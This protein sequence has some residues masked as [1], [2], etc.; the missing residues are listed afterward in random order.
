MPRDAFRY[1][2]YSPTMGRR[3]ITGPSEADII[4]WAAARGA[5]N[6]VREDGPTSKPTDITLIWK[7]DEPTPRDLHAAIYNELVERFPKA[8]VREVAE[9]AHAIEAI[10]KDHA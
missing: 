7:R 3:L 9:A 1:Y 5:V 8:T 6:V 10:F 2:A 4:E